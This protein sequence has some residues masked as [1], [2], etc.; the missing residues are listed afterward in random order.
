MN[1]G[2]GE[3]D[4]RAAEG[5][6]RRIPTAMLPSEIWGSNDDAEEQRIVRVRDLR[7]PFRTLPAADAARSPS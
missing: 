6:N 2:S 4:G 5:S 7:P 1:R 3:P